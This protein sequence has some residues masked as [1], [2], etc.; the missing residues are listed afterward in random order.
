MTCKDEI[1][2]VQF[3]IPQVL[4]MGPT[5]PLLSIFFNFNFLSRA[6]LIDDDLLEIEM[7]ISLI[8]Q[9]RFWV[10]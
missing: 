5:Q 7:K 6:F 2:E 1:K 3:F 10:L 4:F 8:L 9:S